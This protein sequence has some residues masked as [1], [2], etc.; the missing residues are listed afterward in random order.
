MRKTLLITT[1]LTIT[2]LAGCQAKKPASSTTSRAQPT[3]TTYANRT[4][5]KKALAAD[6]QTWLFN[7][8][9][10][11]KQ[12]KNGL[13]DDITVSNIAQMTTPKSWLTSKSTFTSQPINYQQISFKK[14]QQDSRSHLMKSYQKT[15]HLMTVAQVNAA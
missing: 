8:Q 14:W 9:L 7:K 12:T 13:S 3:T 4:T 11:S 15:L 1:L 2:L 10:L 5:T 6:S